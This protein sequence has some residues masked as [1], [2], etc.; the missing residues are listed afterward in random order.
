MQRPPLLEADG[1]RF[2]KTRFETYIKSKDIYL[3]HVIQNGDFVFKMKDPETMMYIETPYE[4]LKDNEKRQLGKNNEAKLTYRVKST[5]VSSCVKPPK[6]YSIYSS[7][8]TKEIHKLRIKRLIFSLKNTRSSQ[9][10]M[11]KLLIV[12]SHDSML[13]AKVMTIV[14]A[15][16]LDTLPLEELISNLKV[17]EMI[18]ASDGVASKPIKEKVM[19]IALKANVTRGQTSNDSV[20][21]DGSDED[22][23]EE[24]EFDRGHGNRS[25][26][27]GIARGKCNCYGYGSKNY[28]VDNCPKAKMRK[29][30]VGGA[31]SHSDDGDQI[32]KDATCLMAIGS[33]K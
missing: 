33:Q 19:P 2:W 28:F 26:G 31:W 6:K 14:E 23:D 10:H 3:W 22:E 30:F 17:Y 25:K 32:E 4:K 21:Q 24:E 16:Y 8:L 9:S 11:K 15:K 1:F 29:A 20:C 13:L 18:L 7:S 5:N 12:A 27:V